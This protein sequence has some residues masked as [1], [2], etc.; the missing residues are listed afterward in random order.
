MARDDKPPLPS[1]DERMHHERKLKH[2]EF[3]QNEI[4]RLASDSARV[5]TTSIALVASLFVLALRE[6]QI[7]IAFLGALP[8]LF[9]WA[10]DGHF[11]HQQ[12]LF[13]ERYGKVRS[14]HTPVD[15]S[16]NVDEF[17]SDP[18]LSYCAAVWRRDVWGYYCTLMVAILGVSVF[19]WCHL[20]CG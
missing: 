19:G 4:G 3:I 5:K 10:V 20:S 14:E 7:G 9:L 17:R 1:A 15:F 18:R 2:L 6:N 16:M 11:V 12:L 13:R 8:V